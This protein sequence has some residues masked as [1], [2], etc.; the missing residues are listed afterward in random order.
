MTQFLDLGRQPLANG[1]ILPE[2]LGEEQFYNLRVGFNQDTKLV[3]ILPPFPSKEQL[4][5][6]GYSYRSGMSQTMRN[7]FKQAAKLFP[8]PLQILEIGS[9]D[10]TF[11][12]NFDPQRISFVEPCHNFALEMWN[13]GY[14]GIAKFWNDET[15]EKLIEYR[16]KVDVVYSTNCMSHIP[17]IVDAFSAVKKILAPNGVFVFEEPSLLEILKRVSYDQVYDEHAHL[18]SVIALHELLSMVGL[19]IFRVDHLRNIHGG[20]NRIWACKNPSAIEASVD[21]AILEE[22]GQRLHEKFCY[23]IFADEVLE[24]KEKLRKTLIRHKND[25]KKIISYG[26]TGKSAIVFNYCGIGPELIDYVTDTTP[27]KQGLYTPGTHIPIIAPKETIEADIAFLG[28]WNFE[29]EI[30]ENEKEFLAKGGKFITHVPYVRE[31]SK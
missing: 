22:M 30:C 15:A 12:Q 23:H 27:E 4:F 8:G 21:A 19:K 20:S 25:G 6:S 18:F 14:H 28:A 1:F 2:Y 11:L 16:G 7:H 26:A 29:K 10:G 3:S 9:N 13:K 5:H 24:S 17:E 31:I